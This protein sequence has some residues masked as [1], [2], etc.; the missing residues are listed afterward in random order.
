M[1]YII[2]VILIFGTVL[3]PDC[4]VVDN[5]NL[6]RN[7]FFS[8]ISLILLTTNM[9]CG[10][11]KDIKVD[12]LSLLIFCILTIAV[13][14]N[15]YDTRLFSY[16]ISII[17][18]VIILYTFNYSDIGI[19]K[20]IIIIC[21]LETIICYMQF[22]GIAEKAEGT[23]LVVGTFDN[24]NTFGIFASLCF[25]FIILLS[26]QSRFRYFCVLLIS[27]II[28][29]LFLMKCRSSLIC[30]ILS[31]ITINGKSKTL[32]K[33]NHLVQICVLMLIVCFWEYKS[34]LGRLLILL[35]SSKLLWHMPFYGYAKDGFTKFYMEEQ[36]AILN[37]FDCFVGIE[38]NPMDPLNEYISYVLNVG[39]IGIFVIILLIHSVIKGHGL[40]NR[41]FF[42]CLL[43]IIFLSAVQKCLNYSFVWV[44]ALLS[45]T[46]ENKNKLYWNLNN[47]R[48]PLIGLCTICLYLISKDINFE[49]NWKNAYDK[50][51]KNSVDLYS[52]DDYERLYKNWNGN[53]YFLYN[54]ASV[55]HI[56][57]DYNRSNQLL[58]QYN[59]YIVDYQGTML[60]AEN[61]LKMEMYNFAAIEFNKSY[62]MCPSRFAPLWGCLQCYNKT[63]KEEYIKT[64]KQIKDKQV[65]VDSY[66]IRL[67]KKHCEDIINEN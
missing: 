18:L 9:I 49:L 52:I 20:C 28:I 36:S 25:P 2:I 44:F 65:K 47:L 7:Y 37:E 63:N 15:P 56:N 39:H 45:I 6:I 4:F 3:I 51:Y 58:D 64:A 59:K 40:S 19:A 34:N 41:Y 50:M 60:K 38:G 27:A 12:P 32:L 35:T 14:R 43:S 13:I 5:S 1:Q 8:V 53:P 57:E 61:F 24:P 10:L 42:S 31:Y 55:L 17:S 33:Q 54:Y 48:F 11:L 67:M 26:K 22:W 23:D 16:T 21:A 29:L 66:N 62:R 46:Q 30:I